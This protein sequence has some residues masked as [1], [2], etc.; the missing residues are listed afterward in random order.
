MLWHVKMWRDHIDRMWLW[1]AEMWAMDD[2]IGTLDFGDAWPLCD[3]WLE[4]DI[5]CSY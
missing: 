1:T 2:C 3:E 4:L 5:L